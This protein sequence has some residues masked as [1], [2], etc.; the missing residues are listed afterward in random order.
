MRRHVSTT[1]RI[2]AFA[3]GGQMKV[4]VHSRRPRWQLTVVIGR[5]CQLHDMFVD[6]HDFTTGE[7]EGSR[8][9]DRLRGVLLLVRGAVQQREPLVERIGHQRDGL[10]RLRFAVQ[11]SWYRAP[12]TEQ[13][14][15]LVHPRDPAFQGRSRCSLAT[16]FPSA[17]R[18]ADRAAGEV[19]RYLTAC[20]VEPSLDG[21]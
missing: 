19:A 11:I 1:E 7:G 9:D 18:A 8:S 17:H 15:H 14:H 4:Q 2:L 10:V 16:G 3:T 6:A 12:S 13:C 21:W 5:E 20:A